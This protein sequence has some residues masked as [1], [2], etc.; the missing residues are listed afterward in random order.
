M[1][2]IKIFEKV[3][4]TSIVPIGW[5]ILGVFISLILLSNIAT[6]LISIQ[7][8]QKKVNE[9]NN[10]MLVAQLKELYTNS[11]NQYQI[12]SY[13]KDLYQSIT[14][15]RSVAQAGFD[16]PHSIA[17]GVQKN[18][19]I[20]FLACNDVNE[21]WDKFYDRT[22][23][24]GLSASFDKG[25]NQGIIRFKNFVGDEY[26]GVYKYQSDW[27]Y[28]LI[29]AERVSDINSNTYRSF[30]LSF[31][32]IILLTIAFIIVGY[33]ILTREFRMMRRFT[34]DLVEMQKRKKLE[35]IDISDAP[36]DDVT[37]MAASF[38]SLSSQVNNLLGTFQKFVSK[39]VVNKAYND[40]KIALEGSTKNLTMLFS[41][42]KSFT[43][44][45][46]TLG[47]E[48]IDV[49]NVHYNR[50]IHSVH[51]NNGVVGS[52]IGDAIL[53]VFGTIDSKMSKSY[54]SVRAAWDI[55]RVTANLRQ[56][57]KE[58]KQQ[59]EKE[60]NLTESEERVY[61]AVMLDVGVGIDGGE[62]FYGNIGSNEHM[63]NTVIGDNV[64]SASRL[65][66]LTRTYRLPVIVSAY[67]KD[68]ILQE[69]ARYKF[70]EIDTVQVKGKTEGK[71]IYYPLDT[72]ESENELIPKFEIFEKALKAYYEGD[73][74]TA[75]RE[76]KECSL[77]VAEV[78]LER[79]G[80]KS[81]P[82]DWSGIWT[83]TTK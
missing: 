3:G 58:K 8:M 29:R 15:L 66:G 43:Y 42:I 77:D 12:Y 5:K 79:M 30:A 1:K 67:V 45:T 24:S 69:S 70:Y 16:N 20:K 78:F 80:L 39:D 18:G 13:S 64:N 25:I 7:L 33:I 27:E 75:R 19:Q 56:A 83:M 54:N 32:F 17:M 60:R 71:K 41:D 63:A 44:R 28:F 51:E 37:Y 38:N 53:A 10:K 81:S 49:L 26:F 35:L 6:N 23:L 40:Q 46:E 48:I 65:E 82:E 73:W 57:M 47:N 9:L 2:K 21:F 74:K 68:E 31:I 36:N 76:F 61:Q 34:D 50:V 52:I 14:T 22:A 4:K 59:I 11:S 62:V 55:T 72:N